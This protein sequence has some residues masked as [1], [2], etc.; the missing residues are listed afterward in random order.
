[1]EKWPTPKHWLVA[2]INNEKPK[3]YPLVE[4]NLLVSACLP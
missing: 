2:R 3:Y 4:R 1:M